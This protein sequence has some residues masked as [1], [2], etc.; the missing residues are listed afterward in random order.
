MVIINAMKTV[1]V[2]NRLLISIMAM[3]VCVCMCYAMPGKYALQTPSM[4][5]AEWMSTDDM[6]VI[7]QQILDSESQ[8][9]APSR[10]LYTL[11]TRSIAIQI[12]RDLSIPKM[13]CQT[14]EGAKRI[15]CS[16]VSDW[17]CPWYVDPPYY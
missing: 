14:L 11:K 17:N 2:G 15:F 16:S 13:G 6:K 1:T 5:L 8:I 9:L 4:L 10:S 12:F 7:A 3:A